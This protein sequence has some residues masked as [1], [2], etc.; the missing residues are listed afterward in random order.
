MVGDRWKL[1]AGP[2]TQIIID[3]KKAQLEDLKKVVEGV[4]P[5]HFIRVSGEWGFE[6]VKPSS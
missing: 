4:R 5:G 2:A 1:S 3:G 6:V